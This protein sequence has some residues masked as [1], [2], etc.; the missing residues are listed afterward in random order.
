MKKEF[1]NKNSA[2]KGSSRRVE[3]F[4]RV[5]S[6]WD[7]ID[8]KKETPSKTNPLNVVIKSGKYTLEF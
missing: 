5:R 6:N 4:K 8:W 3:N 7:D 2:G 1:K